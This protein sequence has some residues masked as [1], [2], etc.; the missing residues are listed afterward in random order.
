LVAQSPASVTAFFQ[1]WTTYVVLSP[2]NAKSSPTIM[3]THL[4]ADAGL[5]SIHPPI[6]QPVDRDRAKLAPLAEPGE[7]LAFGQAGQD[8]AD[9]RRLGRQ[10][11]K[12]KRRRRHLHAPGT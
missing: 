8:T 11:E 12:V 1:E 5:E 3:N 10:I 2:K 6:A 9:G 4:Q 7:L